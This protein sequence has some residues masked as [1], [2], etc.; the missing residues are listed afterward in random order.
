[1]WLTKLKLMHEDCPIVKRCE[2][3]GT[4][5]LSYPSTWYEKKGSKY[6]TT[7]CYFQGGEEKVKK[8]FIKDLKADKQIT[9]VEVSGDLF[10]Y[11]INLGKKGQHVMLYHTKRIFF[12]GPVINHYDGHEYWEVASWERKELEKFIKDLS[13]HMDTADIIYI[14]E[15]PIKGIYF[16][17]VMPNLTKNQQKALEI[18]Y[19]NGYYFYPRKTNL[20]KLAK[21]AEIG[22]STFQEHLRKAELKLLPAIISYHLKT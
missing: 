4:I 9:H 17:H 20:K 5:V 11:E 7:N 15:S 1:M 6:A 19:N 3:F 14:K 8:R 16:P 12:V 22:V 18:A 2:R 13:A 21:I 10:T